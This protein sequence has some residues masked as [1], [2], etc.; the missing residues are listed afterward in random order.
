MNELNENQ[1]N[2]NGCA[3][4]MGGIIWIGGIILS[5]IVVSYLWENFSWIEI[6]IIGFIITIIVPAVLGLISNLIKR[7]F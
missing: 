2:K 4:V 5:A 7:L 3:I 6:I 1:Q